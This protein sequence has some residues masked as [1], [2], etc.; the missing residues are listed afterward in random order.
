[1]RTTLSIIRL[2]QEPGSVNIVHTLNIEL[3]DNRTNDMRYEDRKVVITGGGTGI[4]ATVARIWR[5][6]GHVALVGRR[7]Q[8][9]AAAA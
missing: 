9:E 4:G 1:M 3:T 2:Q 6:K 8:R 5:A 7:R